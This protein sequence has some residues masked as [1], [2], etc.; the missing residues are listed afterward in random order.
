MNDCRQPSQT[1]VFLSDFDILASNLFCKASHRY[2]RIAMTMRYFDSRS[3]KTVIT[4]LPADD[5]SCLLGELTGRVS[6]QTLALPDARLLSRS[7]DGTQGLL[8]RL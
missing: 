7:R 6:D 3:R 2:A 1:D 8:K 4:V 5:Y